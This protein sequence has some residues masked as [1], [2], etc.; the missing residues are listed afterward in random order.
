M[1]KKVGVILSGCGVYDGAEVHEAVITMLALDRRGAD[2]VLCAPDVAQLH[3]VNHLTGEVVDGESRNVLVESA[4]IARGVIR[5]VAAVSADE[6]DALILPGGYGAAKNLCDFALAGPD[7]T[8]NP[9]VARLVRAVH[10]Q[11]KPVAAVCIAPALLAKVLGEHQ[12]K[13]TIGNDPATAGALE[14]MGARHVGC[15]VDGLV[16]D[17]ERKLVS[18]PAYMLATRISEAA[19]GIEKAVDALLAMA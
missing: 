9:D 12:P 5:D 18:T 8:V 10:A 19:A 13:L 17:R 7:C 16:V 11:G 6:L 15:P 4:R 14:K 1:A 3:V 2:M